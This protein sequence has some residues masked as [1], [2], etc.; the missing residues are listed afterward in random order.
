MLLSQESNILNT[1]MWQGISKNYIFLEIITRFTVAVS[2]SSILGYRKCLWM[3]FPFVF[4][5]FGSSLASYVLW[6]FYG[7]LRIRSVEAGVLRCLTS[8]AV[9]L[10]EIH[11][12]PRT[13]AMVPLNA[14]LSTETDNRLV[15]YWGCKC[16]LC[17]VKADREDLRIGTDWTSIGR[18]SMSNLW[19]F[20]SICYLQM[21]YILRC[22]Q[23]YLNVVL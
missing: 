11:I 23:R 17:W 10:P 21:R 20:K 7:W 6:K 9:F 3:S 19:R 18:E 15:G 16:R 5:V 14:Y 2:F 8:V 12:S 1:C 22:V 13:I 4:R